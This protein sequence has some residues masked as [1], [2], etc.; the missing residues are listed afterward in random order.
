MNKALIYFLLV[1]LYPAFLRGESLSLSIFP[2]DDLTLYPHEKAE[3]KNRY[4]DAYTSLF[5]LSTDCFGG[6]TP[7]ALSYLDLEV[8]LSCRYHL[9]G[10]WL[11]PL[12][13]PDLRYDSLRRHL[14]LAV[15]GRLASS[16][17]FTG[18]LSGLQLVNTLAYKWAALPGEVS[19]ASSAFDSSIFHFYHDLLENFFS[20]GFLYYPG[21]SGRDQG[22]LLEYYSSL[23]PVLRKYG[24]IA[25]NHAFSF[26][27]LR[28]HYRRE[29]G[30]FICGLGLGYGRA[31][32]EPLVLE[33]VFP[34]VTL[35]Y[36]F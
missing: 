1:A 31:Q 2:Q 27:W 7:L 17:P 33:G 12:V 18:K 35:A 11:A 28:L 26:S 21:E 4:I 3:P 36:L 30:N 23:P 10:I 29:Y 8:T 32:F 14:S 16:Y 13:A 24:R 15:G 9:A 19:V 22:W 20:L 34:S 5:P 25:A 6:I